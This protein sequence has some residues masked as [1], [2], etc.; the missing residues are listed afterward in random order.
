MLIRSE[1]G[2]GASHNSKLRRSDAH[3]E[4]RPSRS[5]APARPTL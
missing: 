4:T 2:L 3:R 1:D 5:S